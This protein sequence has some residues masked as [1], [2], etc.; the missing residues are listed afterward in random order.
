VDAV[1]N[2]TALSSQIG[3]TPPIGLLSEDLAMSFGATHI[4][5]L[6]RSGI[7]LLLSMS[8]FSQAQEAWIEAGGEWIGFTSYTTDSYRN[9]FEGTFREDAVELRALFFLPPQALDPVPAVILQHGS[10]HPFRDG[11][12][13]WDLDLIRSLGE[14]GIAVL[15]PDGYTSRG[16]TSSTQQQTDL[17]PASRV[18]D[19]AHAFLALAADPRIDATNI[20]I[21]GYS[22]GGFV[23]LELAH[24]QLAGALL[25][26][27]R[28]A[29]HAP[30]YPDCQRRWE[31]VEMTGA[32]VLMLLA[33]LD[34]YT[35]AHFCHEYAASTNSLGF[36]VHFIEY[37]GAH[38]SFNFDWELA[39]REHAVFR[40]CPV[41]T[42]R[43]DGGFSFIAGIADT[44]F[45][46]WHEF[47]I[48]VF[49]KCGTR[50]VHLGFH[51]PSR[52]AAIRDLVTFYRDSLR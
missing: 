18:I 1:A 31:R 20:G 10:G 51:E 2:R 35:P 17:S 43:E 25:G 45:P 49:Q 47:V 9:I 15:I 13:R 32:P 28:F 33:E 4:M 39:Y 7:I 37:S 16:I 14:E 5:N 29:A 40:D 44:D 11:R 24:A 27:K 42:V 21:S 50:G 34:D 23:A 22:F 30:I 6:L 38:H 3:Q 41:A 8:S 46:S 19:A 36:P 48:D 12:E 26:E 52:N